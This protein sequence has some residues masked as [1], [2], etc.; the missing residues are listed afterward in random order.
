MAEWI[1]RAEKALRTGQPRLAELYMRRGL[2]ESAA[3][4]SWLFWHDFW[5][6][7]DR[8]GGAIGDLVL[9]AFPAGRAELTQADFALIAGKGRK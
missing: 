9:A 5:G 1:R 3:G 6:A 4:R 8:L 2:A 7:V